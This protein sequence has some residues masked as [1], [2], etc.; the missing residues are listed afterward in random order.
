[1]PRQLMS[2]ILGVIGAA[3]GGALGYWIFFWFYRQGFY[4]LI[5]PGAALGF[6][7]S[8][9]AQHRSTIRGIACGVAALALTVYTAFGV[10][11]L[12]DGD[13]FQHFV[14]HYHKLSPVTLLMTA[15]GTALGY[16]MGKDSGY[17]SF[18]RKPEPPRP[19]TGE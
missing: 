10:W 4:A 6:G 19:A 14:T 15:L 7:C 18:A 5:V 16:W 1:M 12:P 3:I 17:I 13:T 11:T 9:L 2:T 8:L